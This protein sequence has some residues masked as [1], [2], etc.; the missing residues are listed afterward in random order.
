MESLFARKPE[1]I[2]Q[3]NNQN[4]SDALTFVEKMLQRS[5]GD[6]KAAFYLAAKEKGAD[7]EAILAK[8]R[9]VA[10]PR[11]AVQNLLMGNPKMKTLMSLFSMMK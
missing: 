9:S 3:T 8:A 6:A 4:D 11:A 5:G 7:T 2:R 1:N 10:D